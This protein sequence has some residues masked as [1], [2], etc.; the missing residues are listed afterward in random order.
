MSLGE[1]TRMSLGDRAAVARWRVPRPASRATAGSLR[2][3]ATGAAA[4]PAWEDIAARNPDLAICHQAVWMDCMR[5]VGGFLDAT[6]LY[7]TRDGRRILLPLAGRRLPPAKPLLYDSWPL[8]WE[9]ARDSGGLL[10]ADGPITAEDVRQVAA[11]LATMPALRVKVVPST[12]DAAAWAAGA[13]R[14]AARVPLH[15]HVVDLTG[16]FDVV[17]TQ[18]FSKKTREKSRKAERRGIVVESDGTGRLL[19]IFDMLY[20]RSMEHWAADHFLPTPLARRV[21]E[22]RH[23][24]A[25]LEAVARRLGQRCQVWIAWSAGE[26]VSGIVVLGQGPA[27]TYWK[28]AT[29]K[30][31]VRASGATDY[32]HKCAIETACQAGRT[33]YDLGTSGLESLARFKEGLGAQLQNYEAYSF[34]R[35][36][37]TPAQELL[38]VGL[39]RAFTAA[40]VGRRAARARSA[41][42]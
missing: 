3:L 28:G 17:W 4:R 13:P 25:K 26:P 10:S 14:S 39:R 1:E 16:G 40:A 31:L 23:D 22:R 6:R 36:P 8:Y 9:G 5:E 24:H 32:L 20:R 33:R 11:D 41:A 2:L 29:D 37:F 42:G 15:A 27:A 34:E 35:I 18:R 38:R 12:A 30:E 7:E 19:P 21:I